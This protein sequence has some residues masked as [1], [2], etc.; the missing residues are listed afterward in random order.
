MGLFDSAGEED[1]YADE[2]D[3]FVEDEGLPRG[4]LGPGP[5]AEEKEEEGDDED[6]DDEGIEYVAVGK[7]QAAAVAAVAQARVGAASQSPKSTAQVA[8]AAAQIAMAGWGEPPSPQQAQALGGF[9]ATHHSIGEAAAAAGD[10]ALDL[11][12]DA[13]DSDSEEYESDEDVQLT[14][15]DAEVDLAHYT[16]DYPSMEDVLRRQTEAA[17][18]QLA[19]AQAQLPGD[20]GQ[21]P[22]PGTGAAAGAGAGTVKKRTN[23]LGAGSKNG[24]AQAAARR[25]P[26]VQAPVQLP[27]AGSRQE[28]ITEKTA[29]FFTAKGVQVKKVGLRKIS[30]AEQ[31]HRKWLSQIQEKKRLEDEELTLQARQAAR[32][33][34]RQ[35]AT[36]AKKAQEKRRDAHEAAGTTRR[37]GAVLESLLASR[38]MG[39]K[40]SA[41]RAAGLAAQVQ[42]GEYAG[43]DQDEYEEEADNGEDDD[44]EDKEEEKGEY[45]EDEEDEDGEEGLANPALF[46][47]ERL[48]Q[49]QDRQGGGAATSRA[50]SAK[51]D[52]VNPWNGPSDA[53]S[54][55]APLQAE[56]GAGDT[57]EMAAAVPVKPTGVSGD[58]PRLRGIKLRAAK[59]LAQA[60]NDSLL[61]SS[62][63]RAK[64]PADSDSEDCMAPEALNNPNLMAAR[65]EQT[66]AETQAAG[67]G[68]AQVPVD[69][70]AA[71][72][73]RRFKQQHRRA[74]EAIAEKNK[75]TAD[76]AAA[77]A[78]REERRRQKKS[79]RN[80]E[81]AESR[82]ERAKRTEAQ[83]A[84]SAEV[85]AESTGAPVERKTRL[86][87]QSGSLDVAPGEQAANPNQAAVSRTASAPG[88]HAAAATATAPA[89]AP[90]P[91]PGVEKGTDRDA[92][93]VS[94]W[95]ANG[96]MPSVNQ[97]PQVGSA[98]N[99]VRARSSN[100]GK[101]SSNGNSGRSSS[102]TTKKS[103]RSSRSSANGNSQPGRLSAGRAPEPEMESEAE[104][105]EPSAEELAAKK[106]RRLAARL[107]Q[108]KVAQH[109]A[110]LAAE[111]KAEEQRTRDRVAL[112][113]KRQALLK[114]RV[115]QEGAERKL[116]GAEDKY[117]NPEDVSGRVLR[118]GSEQEPEPPKKPA[119]KCTPEMADALLKRMKEKQQKA[120][121]A[122]GAAGAVIPIRDFADWK[123]KNSVPEEAKVFCMT[124]WYPCVKAA[125]LKRGWYFNSDSQSSHFDLKWTLRSTD[126]AQETLQ[127]HQLTNHFLKNI[128]ITTKVGLLRSLQSL[129]W[130]TDI[131]AD[132]I[133]PRGYDLSSPVELGSFV[134]DF[135]FQEAENLLKGLYQRATGFPGPHVANADA[136]APTSSATHTGSPSNSNTTSVAGGQGASILVNRAVLEACLD[137]LSRY[138]HAGS[139]QDAEFESG[140]RQ[141]QDV[142]MSD[143]QWELVCHGL[144]TPLELGDEPP[145][146]MAVSKFLNSATAH[147]EKQGGGGAGEGGL[148]GCAQ[149][150]GTGTSSQTVGTG[151]GGSSG[152]G[153]QGP[154]LKEKMAAESSRRKAQA[155]ARAL[156]DE[157][158]R[159]ALEMV[160]LGTGRLNV[161][162][163]L[164]IALCARS[165]LQAGLN[166]AGKA[167]RNMWIVKPAAK[168]RGRGIQTFNDLPKLLRYVDAGQGGSAHWVAQKY[169]ENPA[170]IAGRK[171]D[172]RQWVVVTDWNPLTVYFYGEFYV[173]ISVDR[174]SCE[175][176]SM[177]NAYVHLVNNSIGKNHQDFGKEIHAEDGQKIEG[178][179]MSMQQYSSYLAHSSGDT[180]TDHVGKIQARMKEI[181]IQSLM[182]GS[183]LI[184]HRKNSWELYGFDF[185]VD[186]ESV[187]WLIEINSSPACD[188]STPTTERYVQQA[189]VEL[190]D[191]VLDVRDYE[192]ERQRTRKTSVRASLEKP[193]TGLWEEVY[194][195]PTLETPAACFGIDMSLRGT[196]LKTPKPKASGGSLA[197]TMRLFNPPKRESSR[198][199]EKEPSAAPKVLRKPTPTSL[200]SDEAPAPV[201]TPTPAAAPVRPTI[202]APSAPLSPRIPL[203]ESPTRG[204]GDKREPASFTDASF[205]AGPSASIVAK[206]V[207][208]R[209]KVA[210]G[211]V[212]AFD[213]S[214]E[215]A[216]RE[217]DPDYLFARPGVGPE[218]HFI[219]NNSSQGGLP[220]GHSHGGPGRPAKATA[221]PIKTFQLDF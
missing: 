163:E 128:A 193:S 158:K 78:A 45:E 159:L 210:A 53:R 60:R 216:T 166:G 120:M 62:H 86:R 148:S 1:D 98:L 73:R 136:D 70:G 207:V 11:F 130:L 4:T 103:T 74:L 217:R 99:A 66:E 142:T 50:N 41:G 160:P 19:Q 85:E 124:G 197:A 185:M 107:Q 138:V 51:V 137:A 200:C 7:S 179:M 100:G 167:A 153:G 196:Q 33:K 177:D 122:A 191:V 178:Y 92:S 187:P 91:A 97:L 24:K 171:F 88:R 121:D 169:M 29:V 150:A 14:G 106:A 43:Y 18:L 80:K 56:G 133:I 132:E 76:A 32:R 68:D 114:A 65:E 77:A 192:A 71:L 173:R 198:D 102:T 199:N 147:L 151:A 12:G 61:P 201:P 183:D 116:M 144:D 189:L 157:A 170:F 89:A 188:Y 195:G 83:Q 13:A 105:A 211:T 44:E 48:A 115:L 25:T 6:D 181:A 219:G 176:A 111:R 28:Y 161:V 67:A 3:S 202:E 125:L 131:P 90:A 174:Y 194:K 39:R 2:F 175:D 162:G 47:A 129:V 184:E 110:A 113:A 52:D 143:L 21:Q 215:D 54:A 26:I 146:D 36:L 94:G 190:L 55:Y 57:I 63:T 93:D 35:K 109:L 23:A 15:G 58:G 112:A 127:P 141:I 5:K 16:N 172:I 208:V 220:A 204:G 186:E 156:R 95:R 40:R 31:R 154:S 218:N 81:L 104:E 79:Q 164:L 182:C 203:A 75:A 213:D 27:P 149:G 82:L 87:Q 214:D 140:E 126:V 180:S 37:P 96:K 64:T 134:L 20:Q 123:R 22:K 38:R 34:L 205:S 119:I 17:R 8:L 9:T 206:T 165:R 84:S 168:S 118:P 10:S 135:Q 72:M 152:A 155:V 101:G 117:A 221:V 46:V 145:T 139:D 30:A 42:S 49:E 212:D 108:V 69:M 59:V 209:P